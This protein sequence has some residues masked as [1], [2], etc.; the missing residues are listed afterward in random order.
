MLHLI[1]IAVVVVVGIYAN[2]DYKKTHN[3]EDLI[4]E[5]VVDEVLHLE[6]VPIAFEAPNENNEAKNV[7]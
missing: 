1:I 3:P 5:E 2:M 4:I 6:G 7:K